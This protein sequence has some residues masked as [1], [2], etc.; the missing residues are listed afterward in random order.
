[1][2]I[3]VKDHCQHPR[4]HGAYAKKHCDVNKLKHNRHERESNKMPFKLIVLKQPHCHEQRSARKERQKL[5]T[6][7]HHESYRGKTQRNL[8]EVVAEDVDGNE[9]GALQ[10][11]QG[12][13]EDLFATFQLAFSHVELH[14]FLVE[15]VEADHF[16]EDDVEQGDLLLKEDLRDE[17]AGQEHIKQKLWEHN[18]LEQF[19]QEVA[20]NTWQGEGLV[21]E[22]KSLHYLEDEQRDQGSGGPL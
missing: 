4:T 15:L 13:V 12:Y 11:A 3:F 16:L 5:E 9:P 21:K 18:Q 10:D 22:V 8:E 14:S 6:T 20:M 1:M 17:A 2:K 19:R 7:K